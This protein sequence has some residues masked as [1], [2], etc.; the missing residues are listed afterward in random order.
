MDSEDWYF[1]RWAFDKVFKEMKVEDILDR[2]IKH[3]YDGR[4]HFDMVD[5]MVKTA[6]WC[7]QDRPDMRPSMGKVAKMLEGTV[8]ITEPTKPTIFFLED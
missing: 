2:Q 1:P 5:R 7:L 4:V 3:C 6:M 8:E